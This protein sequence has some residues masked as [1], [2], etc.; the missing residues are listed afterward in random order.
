MFRVKG[1]LLYLLILVTAVSGN[2]A[3]CYADYQ[4]ADKSSSHYT[5]VHEGH[6]T[7]PCF[8]RKSPQKEWV[9]VRYMGGDCR[10]EAPYIPVIASQPEYTEKATGGNYISFICSSCYFSFKLR[11]PPAVRLS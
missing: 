8:S 7:T 10:Y 3:L 6:F 2:G 5:D 11:G 4:N 9:K 1:I